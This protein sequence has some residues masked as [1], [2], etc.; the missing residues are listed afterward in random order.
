MK[1]CNYICGTWKCLRCVREKHAMPNIL[2]TF[3]ILYEKIMRPEKQA[4]TVKAV[5]VLGF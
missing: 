1:E 4:F 2:H 3:F 5:F